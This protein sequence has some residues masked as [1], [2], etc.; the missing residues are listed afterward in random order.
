M[1]MLVPVLVT[2]GVRGDGQ[3]VVH[4]VGRAAYLLGVHCASICEVEGC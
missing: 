3:R 1:A 4:G 2:M